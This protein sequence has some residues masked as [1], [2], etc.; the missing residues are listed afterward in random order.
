MSEID[1]SWRQAVDEDRT[2]IR[3]D[4]REIATSVKTLVRAVAQNDESYNQRFKD[5]AEDIRITAQSARPNVAAWSGWATALAGVVWLLITQ[6]V[7]TTEA[8]AMAERT[9]LSERLTTVEALQREDASR[10]LDLARWTGVLEERVATLRGRAAEDRRLAD[11]ALK[12]AAANARDRAETLEA[13]NDLRFSRNEEIIERNRE[14][15]EEDA[16]RRQEAVTMDKDE[17]ERDAFRLIQQELNR[18]REFH[19]RRE[20]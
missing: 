12:D 16:S 1:A 5:L 19:E 20:P 15:R 18:L 3:A 17:L 10:G 13:H 9:A 11:E 6:N 14:A 7:D 4:V 8:R 2:A